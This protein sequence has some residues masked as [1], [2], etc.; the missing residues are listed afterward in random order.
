MESTE[1]MDGRIENLCIEGRGRRGQWLLELIP[2]HRPLT[3][4]PKAPKENS[5]S[6][7]CSSGGAG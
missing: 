5:A 1:G 2:H 3:R 7:S 6:E 4:K